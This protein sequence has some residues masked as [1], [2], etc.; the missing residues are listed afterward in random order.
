MA[1]QSRAY[2]EAQEFLLDGRPLDDDL[3]AVLRAVTDEEI[4]VL[5]EASVRALNACQDA[6]IEAKERLGRLKRNRECLRMEA[7]HRFPESACGESPVVTISSD[8]AIVNEDMQAFFAEMASKIACSEPRDHDGD[9]IARDSKG[10][11]LA[12]WPQW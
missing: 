7:A 9:H 11:R 2:T 1:E 12:E 6:I 8:S 5:G 4:G 10:E 3:I